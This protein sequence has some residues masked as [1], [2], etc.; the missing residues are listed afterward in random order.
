MR[1]SRI[2]LVALVTLGAF[3]ASALAQTP[4]GA[5]SK[6]SAGQQKIVQALFEAQTR[7]TAPNAATPLTLDQ[8][9]AMKKPGHE[10]WGEVFKDMKKQGLVTQKNLGE[11]VSSYERHH[12]ETAKLD[13]KPDKAEKPERA[14]KPDKPEKP[15]KPEKPGRR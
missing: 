5:F 10:G 9:A 11:V 8:I 12:P 13:K 6:L 7:S 15:E 4:G 3:T 14:E 2:L 1:T